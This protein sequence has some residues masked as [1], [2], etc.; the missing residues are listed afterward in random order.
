M[1]RSRIPDRRRRLL[2]AARELA[3]ESGWPATTVAGIATRAGVGKGAVYLEFDD[4]A[5]ILDALLTRSMRD[6]TSEVHRRVRDAHH[7]IDLPAIYRF[8]VEELLADPLMRAFYLGDGSVLGD[9]VR[10]VDDDRYRQRFTWLLDYVARLKQAGVIDPGIP[11]ETLARVLS[12]FTIGLL[13]TPANLGPVTDDQLRETVG[14]FA[15][16]L[17]RGLATDQPTDHDTT[18]SAQIELLNSL[19]AQLDDAEQA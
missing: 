19:S 16:L 3:L 13:H 12:A 2:D 17:G 1:P 11:D 8:A 9:H 15:D 4:K 10:T 5:A 6:L 14:L 18:R 7:L